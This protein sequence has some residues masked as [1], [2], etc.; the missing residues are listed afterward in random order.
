MSDDTSWLKNPILPPP[1]PVPYFKPDELEGLPESDRRFIARTYARET[2][3][4]RSRRVKSAKAASSA[5]ESSAPESLR[6]TG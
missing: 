1:P 3:R 4:L 5:L 6:R 2:R